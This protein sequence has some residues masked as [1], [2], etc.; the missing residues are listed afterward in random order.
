MSEMRSAVAPTM[1]QARSAPRRASSARTPGRRCRQ[2]RC[3][4]HV[5]SADLAGVLAFADGELNAEQ[6]C[7]RRYRQGDD[8]GGGHHCRVPP[9]RL[10]AQVPLGHGYHRGTASLG[11]RL[12]TGPRPAG[13]GP[14]RRG[15]E[16]GLRTARKARRRRAPLLQRALEIYERLDAARDLDRTE[17]RLR[18]LGVRRGRRG[19]RQRPKLGWDSLT[20]TERTVVELVAEGL[21]NPQIGERLYVSRRTVQTHLAHVFA[22]LQVSSRTQLAAEVTR[23]QPDSRSARCRPFDSKGGLACLPRWRIGSTRAGV[24]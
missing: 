24:G 10:L 1:G 16:R 7:E 19:V 13:V 23:R 20:P 22:K 3:H 15:R 11:G 17:A 4:Q 21:S 9:R 14:R 18:G 6:A 8:H 2:Q 12:R 5:D